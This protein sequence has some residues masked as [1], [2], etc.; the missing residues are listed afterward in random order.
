MATLIPIATAPLVKRACFDPLTESAKSCFGRSMCSRSYR[1]INNLTG[2]TAH[3][4]KEPSTWR[5]CI[6]R[7][8]PPFN[9]A[10]L[11]FARGFRFSA[12]DT[13]HR[14]KRDGWQPD[15]RP[16]TRLQDAKPNGYST[17][18]HSPYTP[19]PDDGRLADK[20]TVETDI[21]PTRRRI[22]R[23]L[24]AAA[25][26]A[27]VTGLGKRGSGAGTGPAAGFVRASPSRRSL[28]SFHF[29]NAA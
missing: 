29:A 4:R 24:L 13:L 17:R 11:R 9:Q 3:C 20:P 5:L 23:T 1:Q 15:F 28:S 25:L 22:V 2:R 10:W 7:S 14:L 26:K 6:K 16:S 27:I 18:T 19:R 12:G 21:I 8:F